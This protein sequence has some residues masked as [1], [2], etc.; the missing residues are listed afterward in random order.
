MKKE[1]HNES[2]LY[3][4]GKSPSDTTSF[5]VETEKTVST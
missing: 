4:S 5:D 2:L 1:K 3:G